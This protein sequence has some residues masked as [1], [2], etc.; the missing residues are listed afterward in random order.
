MKTI[1]F[2]FTL[3]MLLDATIDGDKTKYILYPENTRGHADYGWLNAHYSF[4]FAQYRDPKRMQFGTLRVLNDDI[5]QAGQGFGDHP[6]DNM[7][8]VTIP[9]QGALKHRDNMGNSSVINAG[10]VQVM[11]AGTGVV[12]SEFNP[13]E[14]ED[15]NLFQIWVLPKERNIQPRYDQ[16]RFDV[17]KRKNNFQ[18]VVSPDKNGEAL[19]INQD[20]YFSLCNLDKGK[21]IVYGLSGENQGVYLITIDGKIEVVSNTLSKRDAIG[22]WNTSSVNIKAIEESELLVI[23]IPMR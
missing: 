12:H 23:E 3:F 21:E 6:H 20:A 4:S 15:V 13:S 1:T 5:I 8:I 19:W 10:E 9:L 7:E 16:K 2:L 17:Q 18:T 22:I 14:E 11:S